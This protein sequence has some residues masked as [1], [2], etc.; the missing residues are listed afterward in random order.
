M[1][2]KYDKLDPL[3]ITESLGIKTFRKNNRNIWL[4]E[5]DQELNQYL[6]SVTGQSLNEIDAD[7]VDWDVLASKLSKD[8]VRKAKDY[9]KRWTSSLDPNL[10]KGKWTPKED[11]LLIEAYNKYGASW[12]KVA[13]KIRTRTMDQCA[14]R[15]TE[16]LDPKTK[17]RL[18]PWTEEEELLLIKQ[19]GIHGTKWRTVANNFKNRPALTCRNRWRKIVLSVV[20]DKADPFIKQEVE[21]ITQELNL[22]INNDDHTDK[23]GI[24]DS[25]ISGNLLPPK[26]IEPR[27]STEWKYSLVEE[28]TITGGLIHDET[29]VRNLVA[30]AKLHN[31]DITIHQHIH[32]HY[33]PPA[34]P[35]SHINSN[36]LDLN[37][38]LDHGFAFEGSSAPTKSYFLEP[39]VQLQRYQHFNYL[40]PATE[41]PKLTSSNN[42]KA[43]KANS[44]TPSSLTPLTKAVHMAAEQEY[45]KK[46]KQVESESKRKM[47][48]IESDEEEEGIDF[49][50][51]MR[52]L[53]DMPVKAVTKPVSQHHPLHQTPIPG[54][55][56]GAPSPQPLPSQPNTSV[57]EIDQ[58]STSSDHET[59]F[60]YEN[61]FGNFGVIPFNPS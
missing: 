8:G 36:N 55:K 24:G 35:F 42:N 41:V 1:N 11:E 21:R 9:K 43:N 10:K 50:E 17:D 34:P 26:K 19:V 15:Y 7:S 59:S 4:P 40:P 6:V 32:H 48:K 20:K 14:K 45:G 29:S 56:D 46:R 18:N 25:N 49:W 12:Q 16:I 2:N 51:T 31:V 33:S 54:A 27:I 60:V 22:T 30:Y 13:A 53:G 28:S 23:D 3:A 57:M 44:K 39:D 5:E 47:M 58:N 38:N 37:M 61:L 52:T